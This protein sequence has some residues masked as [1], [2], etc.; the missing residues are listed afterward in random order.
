MENTNYPYQDATN[1]E[2]KITPMAAE[3]LKGAAKWT[4]LLSIVWFATAAIILIMLAFI[5]FNAPDGIGVFGFIFYLIVFAIAALPYYFLY[6]FSTQMQ[7]ALYAKDQST[8]EE[9]LDSLKTSFMIQGIYVIIGIV[10][11]LIMLIF[12]LVAGATLIGSLLGGGYGGY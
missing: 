2:M 7:Y 9:G 3:F 1:N 10:I 4:K 12:V 5:M 8:L 11:S 6:R